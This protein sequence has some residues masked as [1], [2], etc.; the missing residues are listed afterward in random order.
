MKKIISILLTCSM[1]LCL[2]ACNKKQDTNNDL[3]GNELNEGKIS[4]GSAVDQTSKH[5]EQDLPCDDN[6]GKISAGST[7]VT[8]DTNYFQPQV[9][10]SDEHSDVEYFSLENMSVDEIYSTIMSLTDIK[11]NETVDE[12][13][14]KLPVQPYCIEYGCMYFYDTTLEYNDKHNAISTIHYSSQEQ[15]DGSCIMHK[16]GTTIIWCVSDYNIAVALYD[17]FAG[18]SSYSNYK[19]GT[20][21]RCEFNLQEEV[22]CVLSLEKSSDCYI[23]TLYT[24]FDQQAHDNNI[25]HNN[26]KIP[27]SDEE[28]W[29]V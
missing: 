26:N 21:W 28:C 19:D 22:M 10:D 7:V 20:K 18:D 5:F 1:L 24:Q 15:M 11:E 4:A 12:Y 14:A 6:T 8:S 16:T 25:V 13:K 9:G 27:Y 2:C 29:G 3:P 23:F 17:K